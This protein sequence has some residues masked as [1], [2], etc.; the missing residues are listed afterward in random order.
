MLIV[1]DILKQNLSRWWVTVE[2]NENCWNQNK[3]GYL[4]I[5]S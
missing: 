4:C 5:Q 2:I 1:T 3:Q